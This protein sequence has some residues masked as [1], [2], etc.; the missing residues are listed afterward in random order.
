M[1]KVICLILVCIFIL[2]TVPLTSYSV[3][4]S[5]DRII[6]SDDIES[7]STSDKLV[8]NGNDYFCGFGTDIGG[9]VITDQFAHSGTKSIKQ[10]GR[11]S[12]GAT[13]KIHNLFD[14]KLT[15]DDAGARYTVSFYVYA[16]KSSGVYKKSAAGVGE[17][18]RVDYLYTEEELKSSTGCKFIVYL[19]GPDAKKYKYRTGTV[20]AQ[21]YD[22]PWNEWTCINYSYVVDSK[23][24]PTDSAEDLS[25][26]YLES[27]RVGNTG[28]YSLDQGC[29]DTFYI[30]DITVKKEDENA[31][32]GVKYDDMES[33]SMDEKF[34]VKNHDSFCG[35][36]T[37]TGKTILS[38]KIAHSGKKSITQ[39]GRYGTGA[40]VKALNLFGRELNEKDVGKIFRISFYV[41]FDKEAGVYKKDPSGVDEDK[42]KEYLYTEDE[43]EASESTNLHVYMCGPDEDRF[44]YRQNSSAGRATYVVPWNQWTEVELYYTVKKEFLP[45]G[46]SSDPYIN[47]MRIGQGTL[48]YSINSGLADTFYIDDLYVSEV[49]A[50]IQGGYLDNKVYIVTQ[51]SDVCRED[52]ARTFILEYDTSGKLLGAKIG[53]KV[54]TKD[55]AGKAVTTETEYDRKDQSSR[56]YTTVC[57]DL[58]TEPLVQK[59]E[60]IKK[61]AGYE[62]ITKYA[63]KERAKE[64]LL[65]SKA[66]YKD[67]VSYSD[68]V[69]KENEYFLATDDTYISA[70]KPDTNYRGQGTVQVTGDLSTVVKFDISDSVKKST[71]HAYLCLYTS[72]VTTPGKA[73]VYAVPSGWTEQK[74]TYNN[75]GEIGEKIS[76]LQIE[77]KDL[78]YYFDISSYINKT[79]KDGVNE[80]SFIVKTTDGNMKFLSN[81][82]TQRNYKPNLI[83]EGVGMKEGEK[84][85][86]SFD[87]SNYVTAMKKRDRGTKGTYV[88]TPTK[89]MDSIKDYNPVTEDLTL[90]KYGSPVTEERYQATGFFYTKKIDDR[91]WIIDPEGYKQ[92]HVAVGVVKPELN[93]TKETNAFNAK[94]G[95]REKWSQ[96]VLD[97]LRPYGFN[98]CGPWSAYEDLLNVEDRIPMVQAVF[99]IE[100][101]AGYDTNDE[102]GIM[103]VFDPRFEIYCD[104]MAKTLVKDFKDNP[105]VL[106]WMIENEPPAS[107]NMLELTLN[108]DSMDQNTI[109]SYHTAWEWLKARHGENVT[110]SDVTDKDRFDWVEFVY[111]RYMKVCHDAIK[112]YAPNHMFLGPKLDKPHLA[113][114]RAMDDWVD[115]V[116]YDYY[117]NAWTA[118]LPMIDR[119]YRASGRP[120]INAEWYCKGADACTE[121][122]GLTNFSGVG[123]Q[124]TTQAE[125]GYYY[126]NF[127]L[128][129]LESKVFVGWQWFR[130]IDNPGDKKLDEGADTNANKGIY[131][132]FYTPWEELLSQMKRINN[133][134]YS[135]AD[136]FDR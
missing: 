52:Y 95:T 92:L 66:E 113:S 30:D 102:D 44:L 121:E 51:Y 83:F 96:M 4:I 123:Y 131:T 47:A 107:D 19:C 67:E 26:P 100:F 87:Y 91:W 41:Y 56:I 109:Y 118:E 86:S 9:T 6:K 38:D 46:E 119:F 15:T 103:T 71:S 33:Y 54:S 39:T 24:L 75:L 134:V 78:A 122:T 79:V 63:A 97:E 2:G 11:Y 135:L 93:N 114:F 34:Y 5:S 81:E 126:Q 60:I 43:L 133:N 22:I 42:R 35:F 108:S 120:M 77:Y 32:R 89:I 132:N 73:E 49:G 55:A 130:Y 45:T 12:M 99:L 105:Y 116:C 16:D 115:I 50:E 125:R 8:V 70:S 110:L 64:M 94:Y 62:Y 59:S 13:V 17:S 136:Y 3:I 68:R 65:L 31:Y 58:F 90:N 98:G 40:T 128:N 7:H 124:A 74:V 25:D 88:P 111:D 37:H 10:Y 14:K 101:Q 80:L 57:S 21:Y 36:G 72:Q 18:E 69:D 48:D 53:D 82:S 27:I 28:D 117:G 29:P 129:M 84:K 127:V 85:V 112:K 104:T 23:Y 106:G 20:N 61:P 76:E 1:K